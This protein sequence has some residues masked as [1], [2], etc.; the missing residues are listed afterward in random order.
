MHDPDPTWVPTDG[1]LK[2]MRDIL[3]RITYK[4]DGNYQFG[5]VKQENDLDVLDIYFIAPDSCGNGEDKPFHWYTRLPDE[6]EAFVGD[7]Y[8]FERAFVTFVFRELVASEIH[9][10][11][12][13]FRYEAHEGEQRPF[14]P[15]LTNVEM[16]AREMPI[17]DGPIA[18]I[19]TPEH[20]HGW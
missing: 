14:N 1:Q 8:Q 13:W 20:P 12:E 18:L 2:T 3:K 7:D 6:L 17:A 11:A 19:K 10:V 16:Y 9:E 4:H 15:H 5:L